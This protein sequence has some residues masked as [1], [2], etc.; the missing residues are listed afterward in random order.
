MVNACPSG[1]KAVGVA[2][3]KT[4]KVRDEMMVGDGRWGGDEV[5]AIDVFVV[6]I[7][8]DGFCRVFNGIVA[9]ASR[10]QRL[11]KIRAWIRLLA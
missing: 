4:V 2:V 5:G 1:G 7:G 9:I 11:V 8:E 3:D 6:V 10:M